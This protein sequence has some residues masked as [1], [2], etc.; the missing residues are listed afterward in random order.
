VRLFIGTPL[1]AE[2]QSFYRGLIGSLVRHHAGILRSIPKDSA[3][4][5]YL[6][7]PDADERSLESLVALV[8]SVAANHRAIDVLIGP[9]HVSVVGPRPRLVHAE[10]Q[11]GAS[12]VSLLTDDLVRAV[13][14]SGLPLTVT[15]S[16]S[17]HVTLAR[18]AKQARRS[19]ARS[20]QKTLAG[21]SSSTRVDRLS[22]VQVIAS[23]LTPSGPIYEVRGQAELV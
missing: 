5:T 19:D 7:S 13:E 20:V 10:I 8:T 11:R 16:R 1:N 12:E 2:N 21:Q 22:Y 15:P 6:F 18:F 4:L 14:R 17:P 23:T 9:P 3:H